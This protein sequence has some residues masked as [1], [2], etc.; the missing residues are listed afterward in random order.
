MQ[1]QST[2]I[3]PALKALL[4]NLIDYA[5]MFPPAS[6][7]LSTA[8]SNYSE[9]ESSKYS[10]MLHWLVIDSGELQKVPQNLDG[11]LSILSPA[12]DNRAAAIESKSVIIAQ[13]P[14]YCEVPTNQLEQLEAVKQSNCFA[15]IRT[16]GV[17]PEAI[18]APADVAKFINAC[19]ERRLAFKATA[20]LHHPIRAEQALTYQADAPRAVMHGFLNV[21]MAAAFS[22]HGERNIEDII[23]DTDPTAFKFDDRAHW[24]SHSLSSEQVRDARTN[25]LHSIG[26]CSFDE[27]VQ[28]LQQLGLI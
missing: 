6:V 11:R 17:K 15:K 12:D 7:N 4:E 20:G 19:A 16:G 10:W 25:F 9:Y 27:P 21:L 5:G 22:W 2:T 24:R 28:E 14:V 26:S 13:H 8:L 1:A 23:C 3:A 18:P